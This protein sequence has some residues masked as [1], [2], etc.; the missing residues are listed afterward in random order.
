M[1]KHLDPDY[2]VH[3]RPSG[4]IAHFWD[5]ID[6]LGGPTGLFLITLGILI[7]YLIVEYTIQRSRQKREAK[8]KH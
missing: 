6:S 2:F 1:V 5:T 3:K 4:Y 7:F 8:K